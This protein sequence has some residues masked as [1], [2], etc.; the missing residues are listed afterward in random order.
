MSATIKV[1]SFLD[2]FSL[3]DLRDPEKRFELATSYEIAEKKQYNVKTFY[4]TN[5][6]VSS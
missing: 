1:R 3:P 2:Y 4:S 5:L 6:K